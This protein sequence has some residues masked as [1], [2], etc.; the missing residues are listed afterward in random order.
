M[1]TQKLAIIL[2]ALILLSAAGA[3]EGEQ[4]IKA[5]PLNTRTASCLVKVTCDPAILPLTFETIDYLL[6]SSGVAGRA[7]AE[8]LG[9]PRDEP[10]EYGLSIEPLSVAPLTPE[11][12]DGPKPA[13]RPPTRRERPTRPRPDDD[14]G[15]EDGRALAEARYFEQRAKYRGKTS[16][17][18]QEKEKQDVRAGRIRYV[19]SRRTPDSGKI[20]RG[21]TPT[22]AA[23]PPPIAEQSLLFRL[24][25]VFP[26][27]IKPAA[28]Q[29]MNALIKNLRETLMAADDAYRTRVDQEFTHGRTYRDWAHDRLSEALGLTVDTEADRRTRDQLE[30][31]VD[32]SGWR[33]EMAFSDAMEQLKNSVAPPLKL[34]VLWSDLAENAEID[35]TTPIN[36]DGL[37]EAPLSKALDLLLKSVASGRGVEFGYEIDGGV[38]TIA[39]AH[40]L[41][42]AERRLSQIAQTDTPVEM[43]LERRNDLF[44]NKQRL[45]MDIARDEARRSAIEEQISRIDAVVTDKVKS[46]FVCLELQRM[47]DLHTKRLE[48]IN[49]DVDAAKLEGREI[50]VPAQH[51]DELTEK[52]ARAKIDL[53][54]RHDELSDAVGG[55]RL[56]D[57]NVNLTDVVIDLAMSRAE[58]E[59]VSRQL[60]ETEEQLKTASAFDPEISQIR[61]AQE[62]LEMAERRVSELRISL[63]RLRE[64]T[65]TV[66][67]GI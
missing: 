47:V 51:I 25:V 21:L 53:A 40:S 54:K 44:T 18:E 16:Y 32:L 27:E 15:L 30:A 23:G 52:L 42:S 65:V 29:F 26:E 11:P 37:S 4:P 10:Y 3:Q 46:D 62:E 58:F 22:S 57:L 33:P 2:T 39:T 34:V 50:I 67:G 41:P 45:E 8:V 56:R 1:K 28:E 12:D 5:G 7:V 36:I 48:E 49:R 19:T 60:A 59:V 13:A 24:E 64:P 35:Q 66:L 31:K 9:P 63:E 6:H 20:V 61:L 17:A 38:I 14:E 43:L 55:N